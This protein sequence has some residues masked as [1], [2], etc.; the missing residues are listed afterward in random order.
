MK[1]PSLFF[2]LISFCLLIEAQTPKYL[3][4]YEHKGQIQKISLDKVD[5]ITLGKG[6]NAGNLHIFRSDGNRNDLAITGVDSLVIS[7]TKLF[8]GNYLKESYGVALLNIEVENGEAITSKENADYKNC[9][10]TID[11]KGEY[12]NY[13]GTAR[14]KGRGNSSWLFYPKKPYRI[15]LD[16]KAEIL[17]LGGDRDWV[18]L[19]NYRD[20]TMLMNAYGFQMARTMGLSYTNHTRYV[21]VTLN[22][23]YIGLYQLTEQVEQGENRVNIDDEKGVLL[24]VDLDDGPSLSPA[25]TNNFWSTVYG[26]PVSVKYPQDV[27]SE[28]LQEIKDDFADLESCIQAHNYQ[29]ALRR[30]DL[31]SLIKYLIIQ[32]MAANVEMGAPRSVYMY[33]DS[34]NVYHMG[35]SWD[36]DA[37]FSYG[38]QEQPG[39]NWLSS[40][41]YF[42]GQW[43]IYGDD[44]SGS[45]SINRFFLNMFKDSVYTQQYKDCWNEYK[46]KFMTTIWGEMDSLLAHSTEAYAHN[47]TRWPI[48]PDYTTQVEAFKNFLTAHVAMLDS[49]IN[50]Y[51]TDNGRIYEP[52]PGEQKNIILTY[53]I[54][55]PFDA[56]SYTGMN[57][58]SDKQALC[59]AFQLNNEQISQEVGKSILFYGVN[60]D[61][62]LIDYNTA[63]GYGHWFNANG[64]VC[65]WGDGGGAAMMASEFNESNLSFNVCQFPGRA[66]EDS[67]YTLRQA[68]VY[69]TPEGKRYQA[70]FIFHITLGEKSCESSVTEGLFWQDKE[71]EDKHLGFISDG[72]NTFEVNIELTTGYKQMFID[73]DGAAIVADLGLDS[74]PEISEKM[75]A[76]EMV[77]KGYD[78]SS[79][80]ISEKGSTANKGG[81]WYNKQG[82]VCSWGSEGTAVAAEPVTDNFSQGLQ[83]AV[84]MFPDGI[85]AGD[86]YTMVQ[87]LCYNGKNS[88]L[89][90]NMHIK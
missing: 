52:V 64:N 39:E 80:S 13:S 24:Y 16:Q 29:N 85:S 53:N 28:K 81:F 70:T 49:K 78:A 43:S 38:W 73:L 32:D 11:G 79:S 71:P 15:K 57:I 23:E 69:N 82:D 4:L 36:F 14:I 83:M 25:A 40:H 89:R 46:D 12:A 26:V 18:L 1:K 54:S 60:S 56:G 47:L 76:G 35:P 9:T 5:S 17:G 75:K 77:I 87:L 59:N 72:H 20:P 62:T 30:I 2:L 10:V 27:T 8:K 74:I 21:E 41:I 34:D 6:I 66:M 86:N 55:F 84:T 7:N 67:I 90:F 31:E 48:T 44:P 58:K 42:T 33:K 61:S 50:N 51:P 37:G 63:N 88:Y 45:N 3:Y 22:G 65:H 68:L 19:S